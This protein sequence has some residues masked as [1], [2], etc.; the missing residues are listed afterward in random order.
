MNWYVISYKCQWTDMFF[1]LCAN[2]KWC[3]LW[4]YTTNEQLCSWKLCK[5]LS[6]FEKGLRHLLILYN[7]RV[8]RIYERSSWKRFSKVANF[9]SLGVVISYMYNCHRLQQSI[10][11]RAINTLKIVI[12]HSSKP[13]CVPTITIASLSFF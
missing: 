6:S 5:Q 7:S 1:Q 13:V 2:K 12:S 8:I 4:V 3:A 9:K 10:Y 11:M